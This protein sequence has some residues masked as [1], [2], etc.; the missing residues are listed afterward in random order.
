MYLVV[1]RHAE[2]EKNTNTQFS[3]EYDLEDLT[4]FG[5]QQANNL[6]KHLKEFIGANN[7]TCNNIYAANST[8]S[9]ETA[10]IISS[11]LENKVIVE[12]DL[13]STRPGSLAGKSEKEA[14]LTNPLFIE[15]LYL[16]RHG[17]FNAY[18][19]KVAEG[20][21]SKKEFEKRVNGCID[22]ILNDKSENFKVIIAHRS[23]ITTILLEF[24]KLYYNYPKNFSGHIPLNLGFFSILQQEN[25]CTWKILKVNSE[26]STIQNL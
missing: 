26:I 19:F 13:R 8:R 4:D 7:L 2:S 17:L 5:R 11:Y 21:E 20:K 25:D 18:D 14:M 22:K 9:I 6:G 24:A 1:I 16:F 15:Q 12:D 10:K 23:S 3:S